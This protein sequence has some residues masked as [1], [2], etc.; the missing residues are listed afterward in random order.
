[1][2]QQ[3]FANLPAFCAAPPAA[4]PRTWPLLC[5]DRRGTP[6]G[7]SARPNQACS[8]P[9]PAPRL[10]YLVLFALR[11]TLSQGWG[12]A[13]GVGWANGLPSGGGGSLSY[14]SNPGSV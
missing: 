10:S 4:S 3:Q 9:Q 5:G 12:R 8:P 6:Q 7:F 1:M 14:P 13:W 2:W 11:R